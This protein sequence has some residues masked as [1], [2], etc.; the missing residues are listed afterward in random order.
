MADAADSKSAVEIRVG[1]SPISC[2]KNTGLLIAGVPFM[3]SILRISVWI[4]PRVVHIRTCR[5][6]P[7]FRLQTALVTS[8]SS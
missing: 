5:A 8:L 6:G 4:R 2:I 7:A 1:S 3:S